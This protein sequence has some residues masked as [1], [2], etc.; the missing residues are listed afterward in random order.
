MKKIIFLLSLILTSSCFSLGKWECIDRNIT[1][2]TWRME[3]PEGW[4]VSGDSS[5][6]YA[7]TF[8]PD[9]NHSWN[10]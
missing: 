1:C 8:V 3:V 9:K 4:V 5:E 7:M 6:G 2:H 10:I